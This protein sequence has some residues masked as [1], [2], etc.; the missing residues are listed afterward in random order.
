MSKSFN[1]ETQTGK[2]PQTDISGHMVSAETVPKSPDFSFTRLAAVCEQTFTFYLEKV[3]NSHYILF[4][5]LITY[6]QFSHQGF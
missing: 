3:C 4:Y 2:P 1:S 5:I 6:S